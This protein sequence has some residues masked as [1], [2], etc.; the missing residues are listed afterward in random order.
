MYSRNAPSFNDCGGCGSTLKSVPI[1]NN[2]W[3][4]FAEVVDKVLGPVQAWR[5]EVFRLVGGDGK[6]RGRGGLAVQRYHLRQRAGPPA[7]HGALRSR[8]SLYAGETKKA[9]HLRG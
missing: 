6:I 8:R 9:S 3:E 7:T 1:Y 2:P 4:G 5:A